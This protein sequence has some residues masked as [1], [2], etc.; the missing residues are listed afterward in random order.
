MR[1]LAQTVELVKADMAQGSAV[2]PRYAY[3]DAGKATHMVAQMLDGTVGVA[4]VTGGG[5][6]W[7]TT[8]G[9][10]DASR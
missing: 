10:D 7:L 5:L 9:S 3:N 1:T 6:E 4:K 2:C 8:E